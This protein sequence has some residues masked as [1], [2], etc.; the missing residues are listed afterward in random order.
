MNCEEAKNMM[1]I[2]VFGTLAAEEKANLD[3]HLRNCPSCARLFEK[4][5]ASWTSFEVPD[6]HPQPDWEKS[7]DVIAARALGRPKN[8]RLFGLPGRWAV[9]AASLLVVFALGYFAGRRYLRPS[10]GPAA[11]LLA[12]AAEPSPLFRYAESLEPVLIDFLNRGKTER[13]KEFVD[14]ERK[15][16]QSMLAETRLLQALAASSQNEELGAFLEEMESILLSL[17]NLKPGDRDS[18]DELDR[19]IRERRI[20][21]KLREL[22]SVDLT[23]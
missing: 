2:G 17:A 9:A 3:E 7:W 18:A 20:R 1:T 19:T 13:P 21:S 4:S 6:D 10:A 23:L 12:A 16:I 22:S 11:S 8:W 5:K 14:L 15:I